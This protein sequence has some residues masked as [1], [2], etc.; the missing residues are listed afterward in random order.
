MGR[1]GGERIAARPRARSSASARA[2]GHRQAGEAG[3]RVG[4]VAQMLGAS[5]TTAGLGRTCAC[6]ALGR[7]AGEGNQVGRPREEKEGMGP[8]IFLYFLLLFSIFYFMLFSFELKFEHKFADYVNAQ[9]EQVNI[10]KEKMIQHVVQQSW[11]FW[12]LFY[13][14]YNYM[15]QNN[16]SLFRKKKRKA[17]KIEGNTWIWWILENKFYTPNSV[18]Y[19]HENTRERFLPPCLLGGFS[20]RHDNLMLLPE[21]TAMHPVH[22]M[23]DEMPPLDI[24][25]DEDLLDA[26]GLQGV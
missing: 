6:K 24:V 13:S 25:W 17:R 9:P 22:H 11:P 20:S 16:F 15:K 21:E 1:A 14:A 19:S 12:V 23:I 26:E 8:F 10:Q 18:C 5:G 7:D 2:L 3:R 4:D